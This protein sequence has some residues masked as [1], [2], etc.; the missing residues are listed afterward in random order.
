MAKQVHNNDTQLLALKTLIKLTP[1]TESRKYFEE[2]ITLNDS[3]NEKERFFKKQFANV[4]YQ[5]EKM[6][7]KTGV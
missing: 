6:D 2:Y 4:G 5:T 1:K 7:K 3:L